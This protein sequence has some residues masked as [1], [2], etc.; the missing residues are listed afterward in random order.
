MAKKGI[1]SNKAGTLVKMPKENRQPETKS[2]SAS[3]MSLFGQLIFF[4]KKILPNL[5]LG[6]Q[7]SPR[8][9]KTKHKQFSIRNIAF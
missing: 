3:L 6:K 9:Y 1:K 2:N 5:S 4:V 8:N 7:K